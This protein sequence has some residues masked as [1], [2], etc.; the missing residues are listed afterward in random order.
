MDWPVCVFC[1]LD[2]VAMVPV[3]RTELWETTPEQK[4]ERVN[5]LQDFSLLVYTS[6]K[7][8]RGTTSARDMFRR[9]L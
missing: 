6:Y 4:K 7:V 1:F 2:L 5:L 3:N 9:L 8:P